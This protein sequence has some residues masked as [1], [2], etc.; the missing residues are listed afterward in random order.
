MVA[1]M[2]ALP[3]GY[4]LEAPSAVVLRPK[5]CTGAV[6]L[7]HCCTSFGEL[8]PL[9]WKPGMF[10]AWRQMVRFALVRA[11]VLSVPVVAAYSAA[12]RVADS[13]VIQ[14]WKTRAKSMVSP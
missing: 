12:S 3:I 11:S 2:V 4:R 8:N 7:R 1:L 13:S 10:C 5:D 14:A 9:F 6:G